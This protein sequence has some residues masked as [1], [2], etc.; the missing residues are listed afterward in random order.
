MNKDYVKLESKQCPVCGVIHQYNCGLLL[1]TKLRNIESNGPNGE[2]ITGLSLCEG[3]E[4]L[5][6][7]GFVALVVIDNTEDVTTV[8]IEDAEYTGKIIHIKNDMFKEMFSHKVAEEKELPP[9]IYIDNE[10][11]EVLQKMQSSNEV[12]ELIN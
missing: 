5:Y 9:M 3:H 4:K 12:S 11:F 2:L 8:T 10:V 7:A 1:N 6:K